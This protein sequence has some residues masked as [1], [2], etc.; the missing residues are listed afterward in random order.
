M[1]LLNQRLLHTLAAIVRV[2]LELSMT[3]VIVVMSVWWRD[4]CAGQET[5]VCLTL[6]QATVSGMYPIKP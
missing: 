1:K 3:T 2:A 6:G 4:H 5:I